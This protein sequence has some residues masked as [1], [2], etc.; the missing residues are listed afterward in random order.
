MN[1]PGFMELFNEGKLTEAFECII[2]DNP[3][4]SSSGR[5]CHFHCKMR[6]RREDIDYPVSQGEIHRYIADQIYKVGKDKKII[7]GLAK[8]RFPKTGK[9]I[10]IIGAGP[11][12]LT[13]AFYLARLG[14]DVVMYEANSE[15]GGILRY[16]IPEYRLPKAVLRKEIAFIQSMGVKILC[17]KR[18]SGQDLDKKIKDSDAVFLAT[19]AYKSMKLGIPG[20]DLR[21]VL[22]GTAFLGDV[23][24]GKDPLIGKKIVII[25]AGNVAVDAARTALRFNSEVT[26]VYRREKADMPANKEEIKGAESEGVKFIFLANP[27][28]I[29][30]D[31]HGL[32][33]GLI[34]TRMTLGEYDSSGRRKPVATDEVFEIPCDTVILAIGEKVDAEFI[35]GCG[36]LINQDGTVK[37]DRFD[38][39]TSLDKVYAGGDLVMGPATAVEAMSDGKKAARII[40]R[41]LSAEDRFAKLFRK[42]VYKSSVPLDPRASKKLDAEKLEINKRRNNFKEV[43]LGLSLKQAQAEAQRCLRCDVQEGR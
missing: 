35:K 23:A 3:F 38:L 18:F 9:K 26:I 24:V 42:F 19:G 17:N 34:A 43:S 30:G 8:E 21:G 37:A 39:K 5:I 29:L 4:P 11:C 28:A 16:G 41:T 10:S 15:P 2:R 40:D 1:I 22:S 14:H 33:Q 6:C 31:S 7:E 32:L 36:I 20:E 25:G 27:K 12:G 13:A